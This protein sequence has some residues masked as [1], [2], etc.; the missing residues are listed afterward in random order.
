MNSFDNADEKFMNNILTNNDKIS[1][2]KRKSEPKYLN[3]INNSKAVI[4]KSDSKFTTILF[5]F[6]L[7]KMS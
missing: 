6:L 7:K 5:N 3:I 4:T 2:L 1:I